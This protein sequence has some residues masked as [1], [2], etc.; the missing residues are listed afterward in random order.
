MN[1]RA[2]EAILRRAQVDVPAFDFARPSG[3]G[4]RREPHVATR[5][6]RSIVSSM[7]AGPML[8]FRPTTSAPSRSSSGTKL[9]GAM[10]SSVLPSSSVVT[11]A[12]IGRSHSPRTARIASA[13]LVHVAER[14]EHEQ[15]DAALE[16]RARLLGEV[17]LRLVDA[18]P[19]P[20]LD[21]N[22]ER[23]D[24]ARHPA[25][26]ARGMPGDPRALQV[27]RVDP[28]RQPELPELDAIGAERIRLDDVAPARA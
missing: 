14:F 27:E 13:D 20:R 19:A 18:G 23:T 5:A 6:S 3:V 12:T 15:V 1:R 7:A 21:A 17:C 16:Q 4:L 26:I 28:I 24:R 10:P 25:L 9:S 22:A 11:C 8:Q 2:Y